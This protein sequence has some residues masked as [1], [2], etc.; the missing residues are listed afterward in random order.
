M[1]VVPNTRWFGKRCWLWFVPGVTIL[2]PILRKAGYE[3]AICE[4]NVDNLTFD[5]VKEQIRAFGPDAIGISN[6]S[7]EY[8]RQLHEC[9][10]LAKEVD[11]SII[12]IAGGVHP[13][14]C[15]ERCMKDP[16]V[17]FVIQ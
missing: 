10:K 9:A 7:V 5:Q 3:V 14:T 17:D 8:W 12:T 16:N 6:M 4:A 2:T 13:T 15:P 1:F 11:P